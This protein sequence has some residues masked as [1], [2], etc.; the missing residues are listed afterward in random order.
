MV[1]GYS[2]G[3][4]DAQATIHAMTRHIA[5]LVYPGFQILDAAGPLSA[6]EAASAFVP[7]S[8]RLAVIAREAGPVSSSCGAMLLARAFDPADDI[9]TLIVAG[10]DGVDAASGCAVTV[11]FRKCVDEKS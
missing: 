4:N 5:L 6:F 7:G 1:A 8:Y 10:G 3:V 9:D 11:D 2:D